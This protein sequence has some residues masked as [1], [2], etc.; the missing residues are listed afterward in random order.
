MRII[1][2]LRNV[3]LGNNGG[4]STIVNSANALRVLGYYPFIVSTTKNFHTWTE[5][6]VPHIRPRTVDDIPD[7]DAIIATGY[8]SVKATINAPKRLGIKMHWIRGWETWQMHEREIVEKVL[9]A[10]TVKIVNSNCLK[11]KLKSYGVDSHIIRPGYDV[12]NYDDLKIRQDNKNLIIGGLYNENRSNQ[13]K[14]TNWVWE[15][16]YKLKTV[17]KDIGFWMFGDHKRPSGFLVDNY[18]RRPTLPEKN[19]FYNHINIWLAPTGLEGLHI[20]PAEAMLTGCPVIGTNSQMSGM[21]EYLINM[22]TGIV[23]ENNMD[24]FINATKEL[25]DK[26]DLQIKFGKNAREEVLKIGSRHQNMEKL[27]QLIQRLKDENI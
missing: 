10:P 14:R 11:D 2:D 6:T 19:V 8:K 27:V 4:S 25:I 7:A 1:F 18:V 5:L 20:P 15:T 13:A 16:V 24:A 17:N 9:K 21:Q 3:G 26:K 23:A 12:D 22:K